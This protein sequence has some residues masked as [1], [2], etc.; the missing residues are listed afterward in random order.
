[1]ANVLALGLNVVADLSLDSNGL[2][3][4]STIQSQLFVVF[5]H[6]SV[7]VPELILEQSVHMLCLS[8]QL[9]GPG[10]VSKSIEPNSLN[11][12]GHKC[13]AMILNLGNRVISKVVG[14]VW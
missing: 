12:F 9:T 2:V 7:V 3:L 14:G 8:N 1:M 5:D 6:L 4:L 13:V 10:H 11:W